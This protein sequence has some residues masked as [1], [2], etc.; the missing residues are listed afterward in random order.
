MYPKPIPQEPGCLCL[1]DDSPERPHTNWRGVLWITGRAFELF[2]A[3]DD[4]AAP[5]LSDLLQLHLGCP[6][7]FTEITPK[8]A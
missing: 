5:E 6:Q 8:A 1:K 3:H 2:I 4:D 7:A